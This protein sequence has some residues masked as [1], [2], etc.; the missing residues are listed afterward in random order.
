MAPWGCQPRGMPGLFK[1]K[2]GLGTHLGNEG[3]S[4][5]QGRGMGASDG[6]C[7]PALRAPTTL[8]RDYTSICPLLAAG[9]QQRPRESALTLLSI[10]TCIPALRPTSSTGRARRNPDILQRMRWASLIHLLYSDCT[11]KCMATRCRKSW[12]RKSI[13]P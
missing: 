11:A 12:G 5:K 9:I 2:R 8:L 7:L 13:S 1:N 4:P 10:G 3:F 6:W